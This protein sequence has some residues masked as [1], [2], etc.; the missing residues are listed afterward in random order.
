[1]VLTAIGWKTSRTGRLVVNFGGVNESRHGTTIK[2]NGWSLRLKL[3]QKH[4]LKPKASQ[5]QAF[6]RK[7]MYWTPGFRL[8]CGRCRYLTVSPIPTIRTSTTIIQ[9]TTS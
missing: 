1:S 6:G 3:R 7:T 4:S 5:L 8:D 2:M 9:Q